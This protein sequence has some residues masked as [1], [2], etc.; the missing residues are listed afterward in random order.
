MPIGG[1]GRG[2]LKIGARAALLLGAI[3]VSG[4]AGAQE[5]RGTAEQQASCTSDVFRLCSSEIPDVSRIVTCLKSNRAQLSS[6]CRAVFA[7]AGGI[8]IAAHGHGRHHFHERHVRRVS[9]RYD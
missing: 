8:R 3:V 4:G 2:F 6:G 9:A 7:P 5:Y 1:A